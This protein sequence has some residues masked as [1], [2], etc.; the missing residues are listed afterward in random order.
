M[1]KHLYQ[2]LLLFFFTHINLFAQYD[3]K[4]QKQIMDIYDKVEIEG[5]E[6]ES[7]KL[8]QQLYQRSLDQDFKEGALRGLIQLQKITLMRNDYRASSK[9]GDRAEV[10]AKEI[11][12]DLA[13]SSVYLCRGQINIILDKHPEARADLNQ[14]LHYADGIKNKADQHIQLC[15]IYANFAGMYEGLDDFKSWY[16]A[17]SKSLHAITTTPQEHLTDYQKTKYYYLYIFE[18]M[19]MGSYYIYGQ[20]PPDFETAE[21]YFLET[22]KFKTSAPHYFKMNEKDVYYAISSF[23][24]EK[25]DYQKAADYALQTL[26]A[27][28]KNNNPRDRLFAYDNLKNAYKGLNNP[29]E[30]T[31]YLRLYTALN[32]SINRVEKKEIVN[33][34]RSQVQKAISQSEASKNKFILIGLSLFLVVGL[35]VW[36]YI[37]NH[38]KKLRQN[39][40]D[41]ITRL[42]AQ[43]KLTDDN[44]EVT[45]Y[46]REDLEL[47]ETKEGSDPATTKYAMSAQTETRILRKLQTFEKSGRFLKK[48]INVGVLAGQLGTNSRYLSDI[49][50]KYKGGSFSNY[51]NGLKVNYI[52]AKLYSDPKYREYKVS[53]LAEECGYSSPQVFVLAF[54]K[55]HG[56]TPSYFIQSLKEDQNIR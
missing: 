3:N 47:P 51:I 56:V 36:Y 46:N 18:L 17:T 21:R 40:E 5:K 32:D 23:Y 49:I 16:Q 12:N 52:V 15:R 11:N 34:S 24:L 6:S 53:Y 55:I 39:Y 7:E 29:P 9:Y 14:A 30:E 48:D 8:M 20:K 27:E 37:K 19:N 45:A 25:K 1:K 38:Q 33:Q 43:S 35:V 50:K 31:H 54:K 28:K 41:L 42:Q 2:L 10:L 4:A 22:L 13:L 26:V 44:A